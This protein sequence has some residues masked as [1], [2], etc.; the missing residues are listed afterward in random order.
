ML[1]GGCTSVSWTD[2]N[3]F[4]RHFGLIYYKQ[5]ISEKGNVLTK[6]S[7]GSTLKLTSLNSGYVLGME[8]TSYIRPNCLVVQDW[9]SVL[10]RPIEKNSIISK[11]EDENESGFFYYKEK[12]INSLVYIKHSSVG[13]DAGWG[14]LFSGL[15]IGYINHNK[16][17]LPSSTK[18]D[19]VLKLKNG[20][21]VKLEDNNATHKD[22]NHG[23]HCL[24]K[25][26]WY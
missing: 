17:R 23:K 5:S 22:Y 19:V 2:E 3:G 12:H 16:I 21:I 8:S 20:S 13:L 1:L 14:E 11:S 15:N 9:N 24:Y 26:A 18:G 10:S 25:Q 4:D 7:F 6:V